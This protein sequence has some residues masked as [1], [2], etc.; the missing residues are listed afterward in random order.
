MRILVDGF[1]GTGKFDKMAPAAQATALQNAHFFKAAT[2]SKDHSPDIDKGKVRRLKMPVLL[3]NGE[4]TAPMLRAIVEEFAKE[5]PTAERNMVKGSGHGA[6]R[7][8]PEE[9]TAEVSDL[10]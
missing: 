9:F 2:L 8:K 10:L 5:Q 6:P 4:N 3:V 7:E 1:G